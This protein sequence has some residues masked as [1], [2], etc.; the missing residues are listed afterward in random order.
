MRKNTEITEDDYKEIIQQFYEYF[1]NGYVFEEFL[2]VFLEKIGLDEVTVTQRSR[3]GGFDLKASRIGVGGF[4]ENDTIDYYIQA[5]K[6][7]PSQ[8]ISVRSIRE[9]KGTIPFGHKGMFITTARF[10]SDAKKESENDP[11]KPLILVDGRKLIESCI[12]NEIGFIFNPSFSKTAMDTLTKTEKQEKPEALITQDSLFDGNK[13]VVEKQISANNIRARILPLPKIILENLPNDI[14][15]IEVCF[16]D[17]YNKVLTIDKGRN[18]LGG[19]TEAFRKFGLLSED[20]SFNP[21]KTIWLL[22]DGKINI[23]ILNDFCK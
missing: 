23:K 13:I 4:S 12:D 9:L 10:S 6:Y 20:G 2:K 1:E 8:S 3:D 15:E 11:S 17:N 22:N 21:S 5:K 16:N 7:M 18:Y 14:N 19:V